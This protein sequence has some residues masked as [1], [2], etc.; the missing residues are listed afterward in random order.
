MEIIPRNQ[1]KDFLARKKENYI[2]N[3]AHNEETGKSKT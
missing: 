1:S 3:T 2:G